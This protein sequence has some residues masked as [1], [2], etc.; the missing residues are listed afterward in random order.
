MSA[1]GL[2]RIRWRWVTVAKFH[3]IRR[4]SVRE[5]L[6]LQSRV[7]KGVENVGKRTPSDP[8]ETD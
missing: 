2:H 5:R 8:I 1:N 4:V 7:V 3:W 6:R